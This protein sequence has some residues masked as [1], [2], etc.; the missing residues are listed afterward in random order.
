MTYQKYATDLPHPRSP[1]PPHPCSLLLLS[2]SVP[3]P[4]IPLIRRNSRTIAA[5]IGAIGNQPGRTPG[6]GDLPDFDV[7]PLRG[8]LVARQPLQG[9]IPPAGDL[10]RGLL[11]FGFQLVNFL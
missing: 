8:N 3:L 4:F 9:L 11:E 7:V 2:S 6:Q 10:I 5:T 1:A